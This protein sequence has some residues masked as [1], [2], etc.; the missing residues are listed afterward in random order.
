M[1]H[2]F[3]ASR[4]RRLPLSPHD[5]PG[6]S[7]RTPPTNHAGPLTLAA[8]SGGFVAAAASDR[9]V[10]LRVSPADGRVTPEGAAALPQQASA[11]AVLQPGGNGGSD[12]GGSGGDGAPLVAVGLWVDNSVLLLR[13]PTGGGGGAP[14]A[15]SGGGGWGAFGA[16]VCRLEL[17]EQQPRS[18][19]ALE[20][21]GR[22]VLLA[23]TSQG[24]VGG[25]KGGGG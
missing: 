2:C 12:V 15:R 11:L 19:A 4:T 22:R 14:E 5:G 1:D 21:A 3:N 17:W 24:Q 9:L 13:W 23:G 6:T 20:V 10:A 7:S 25:A 16:P 8:G 18:L